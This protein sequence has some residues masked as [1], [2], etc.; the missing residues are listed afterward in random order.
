MTAAQ[1]LVELVIAEAPEL[2]GVTPTEEQIARAEQLAAERA[3][4]VAGDA[5]AF[6]ALIDLLVHELIRPEDA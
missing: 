3:T 2:V 5:V 4:A 6:A 1:Q